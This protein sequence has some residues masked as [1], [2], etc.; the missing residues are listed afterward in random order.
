[1]FQLFHRIFLPLAG[2][3][4]IVCECLDKFLAK[5]KTLKKYFVYFSFCLM[6]ILFYNSSIQADKYINEYVYW[7]N[8]YENAPSY[9][10][11]C[12][13][14]SYIE[15]EKGNFDKSEELIK[16]AMKYDAKLYYANMAVLL[17]EQ[18]KY[19]EAES[20]FLESIKN[21]I[22]VA[23]SYYYLSKIY[24]LFADEQKAK[25][26]ALTAYKLNPYN[27]YINKLMKQFD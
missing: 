21:N 9:H 13:F 25:E 11:A 12:L 5:F 8:A 22:D 19:Q 17:F 2:F 26:F 15:F 6:I 20:L 1:M 27:K 3:I 23:T 4:I 24:L 16:E 18:K 10:V 14:K 7:N